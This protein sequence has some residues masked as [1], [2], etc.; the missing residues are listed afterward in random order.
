MSIGRKTTRRAGSKKKVSAKAPTKAAMTRELNRQSFD[1]RVYFAMFFLAVGAAGM[2]ARAV[3]LQVVDEAFLEQQAN[4]RHIRVEELS[5]HRGTITDRNGEVLAVSTPVDSIAVNPRVLANSP[6]E[7]PRLA[8]LLDLNTKDLTAKVSRN[9][10]KSFVWLKRRMNPSDAA[11]VMAADIPGVS[12]RREYRRYYP[13]GEVTAHLLGFTDIDDK[14]QEGLERAFDHRLTGVPGSKRVLKD[15]LGR[16]VEDVESIKTPED[17][18]DIVTSIDLR[19]QYFAYRALKTAVKQNKAKSGSAVVV[20]VETGEVLA[21]VNQPGYNPNNRSSFKASRVRNRAITDIFEP[22]SALK[23]MLI[24]TALESGKY[25]ENSKINTS[26]GWVKVGSKRIE[27]KNNLGR[28]DL[29]TVL[30]KSS[31]VASTK[32][33]MSL[34]SD[35]LWE[36]LTRFGLGQSTA[37]GFPGE[38]SGLLSHYSNWRD[39]SKATL[40]YGYGLSVTPLQLA[41]AYAVLGN[42]GL[43]RPV[44]LLRIDQEPIARRIVQEDTADSVLHMMESVVKAGGTGT[45]AAIAGYRVAGKTGTSRKAVSGGYAEDRYAAVF[46]G[47]APAS[48]PRIAMVVVVD[49]PNAGKYYGGDV[50]APVFA[51]IASGALRI[52]AVEPDNI[53]G[54]SRRELKLA[55]A[56]R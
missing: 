56:G 33:A 35:Y 10:G 20:D 4:A 2:F 14:G 19:M 31:N 51:S 18:R 15:R 1:G 29:E 44:S 38:S 37:S 16:V 22:G 12:V 41:Q 52:M 17:G 50:S 40:A 32:I 54:D 34:D 49:E 39:I 9:S 25:Q 6:E 26:P 43:Q 5:A 30:Q 45:R 48:N 46:A 21:M 53:Q 23:P 11:K 28:I 36:S 3:Y 42:G 47:V 27:D 13:A 24:A 8:R 7:I 55:E